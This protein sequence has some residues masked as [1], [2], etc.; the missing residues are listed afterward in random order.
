MDGLDIRP[1][2]FSKNCRLGG[3]RFDVTSLTLGKEG[4]KSKSRFPRPRKHR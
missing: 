1:V 2:I 3:E 4:V